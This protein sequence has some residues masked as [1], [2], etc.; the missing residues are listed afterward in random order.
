MAEMWDWDLGNGCGSRHG[1]A[2]L[3]SPYRNLTPTV[4]KK[5][6]PVIAF[7][8]VYAPTYL[9]LRR[10]YGKTNRKTDLRSESTALSS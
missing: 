5:N 3:S 4:R 1:A 10:R 8:P 9:N 2:T 7:A 6:A